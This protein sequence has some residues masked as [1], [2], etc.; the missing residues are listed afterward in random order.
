MEKSLQSIPAKVLYLIQ[1][2]FKAKRISDEERNQLKMML[3]KG[4]EAILSDKCTMLAGNLSIE[5]TEQMIDHLVK[6]CKRKNKAL[7]K[8]QQRKQ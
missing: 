2:L 1:L 6:A 7:E 5:E 4:D 8:E 3:I